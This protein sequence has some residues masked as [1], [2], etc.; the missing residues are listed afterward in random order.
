MRHVR[1]ERQDG[2]IRK[3]DLG[4]R[5]ATFDEENGAL[6]GALLDH[7]DGVRSLREL[8][9]VCGMELDDTVESVQRLYELA[10]VRNVGDRKSVV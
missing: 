10:I 4:G 6:V 9:E 5:V 1:V 2:V 3:L 7:I 8:A